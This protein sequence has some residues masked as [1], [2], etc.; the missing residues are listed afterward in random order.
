MNRIPKMRAPRVI[1]AHEQPVGFLLRCV[2][3]GQQELCL[4]LRAAGNNRIRI[5]ILDERLSSRV[6][7][8]RVG[9]I[10]G[11]P[12]GVQGISRHWWFPSQAVRSSFDRF[13]RSDLVVYL[14]DRTSYRIK[15]PFLPALSLGTAMLESSN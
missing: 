13:T 8:L 12:S 6:Q 1:C 2:G 7:S 4:R 15:K 5:D 11:V 10:V 14:R 3:P 9:W